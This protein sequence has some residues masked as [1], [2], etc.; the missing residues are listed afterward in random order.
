M[1]SS[2]IRR[3]GTSRDSPV[4]A[5]RSRVTKGAA[6]AAS[7]QHEQRQQRGA[8]RDPGGGE[9]DERGD[10]AARGPE[11][12][13][14]RQD[15]AAVEVLD[16][17]RLHVARRVDE[18]EPDA[19]GREAGHED[20]EGRGDEERGEAQGRE[21]RPSRTTT[22]LED[23]PATTSATTDPA[24]ASST[25]MSS[26]PLTASSSRRPAVLDL[27]QAGRQGDEEQALDEEGGAGGE[28]GP[29]VRGLEGGVTG[30]HPVATRLRRQ[31]AEGMGW[32]R[33][34]WHGAPWCAERHTASIAVWR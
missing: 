20:G 15:R 27:G 19:V 28:A 8:E 34:R 16:R 9:G 11:G 10:D 23:R 33:A 4:G 5:R 31:G 17:H 25:T 29:A 2:M 22:A 32:S 6:S 3:H 12:M 21:T 24:P 7:G 1:P 14:G 26:R 18:A 30:G 13:E